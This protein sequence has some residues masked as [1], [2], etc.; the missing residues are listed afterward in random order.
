MER[1]GRPTRQW[2]LENV[3]EHLAFGVNLELWT[4]P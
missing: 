3:Q 2:T 1:P 4:I